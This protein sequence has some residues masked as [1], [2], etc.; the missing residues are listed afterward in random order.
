VTSEH[1]FVVIGGGL[2][3]LAAAR[4]LAQRGRE[5]TVLE[6]ATVGHTGGGSHGGC[7]IFRLGYGDPRYVTLARR[8]GELWAAAE[9]DAGERFLHP[10]PQLTFGAG[11][12]A[13]HEAMRAAGAPSEL[14]SAAAATARFPALTVGGPALLEPDSAVIAA[15][16]VLRALAAAGPEIIT[17]A[18]VSSLSDDGRRVTVRTRG[19]DYTARVVIVAAGPWT[20]AL[21]APAG[22]TVP[23]RARLEQV[24]YLRPA[25]PG[26]LPPVFIRHGGPP[27]APSPYGLPVPGTGEYK[28][29]IHQSGPIT[30]P[31]HQDPEPDPAAVREVAG[32]AA[33]LLPGLD[34]EPVRAE[35][36]VYDNSPD[37]DF[38]VDRIG[39]VVIGSG[40]SGHGFKFGPLFGAWLAALATGSADTAPPAWFALR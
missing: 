34:P 6:Q 15:D 12:A 3:G 7:R 20:R 26:P 2:L 25:R 8:A 18:R 10:A 19:R 27:P 31:D 40:T 21:L 11:L 30:D 36:C 22:I 39:N 38:I 4:A 28:I 32:L 35:R 23:G 1:E 16:R 37:E 17:G 33:E 24:A 5:V 13:V 29:G 14:L 9:A